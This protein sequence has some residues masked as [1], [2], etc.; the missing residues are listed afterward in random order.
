MTKQIILS[1]EIFN[2]KCVGK[3]IILHIKIKFAN[4]LLNIMRKEISLMAQ[5]GYSNNGEEII[6]VTNRIFTKLGH[7]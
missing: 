7:L 5:I 3:K 6:N 4:S 2:Y 1:M